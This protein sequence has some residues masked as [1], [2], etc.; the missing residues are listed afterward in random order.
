MSK[1]LLFILIFCFWGCSKKS[2]TEENEF[3]PKLEVNT[4][5]SVYNASIT[6]DAVNF[7]VNPVIGFQ[8]SGKGNKA[9]AGTKL[10]HNLPLVDFKISWQRNN[11][12]LVYL[13]LL[14]DTD[15]DGKAN[16]ILVYD[17]YAGQSLT[18]DNTKDFHI[19]CLPDCSTWQTTFYNINDFPGAKIVNST[20][21]D[22]GMPTSATTIALAG[23]MLILGDSTTTMSM[24]SSITN[25][26]F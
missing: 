5:H 22:G 24:S 8:G 21:I 20:I 14:I 26:E 23:V 19:V 4:N 1:S 10:F 9:I 6:L 16:H 11:A 15:N 12:N 2:S 13:N 25:L 17:D 7:C 3:I 18:Y